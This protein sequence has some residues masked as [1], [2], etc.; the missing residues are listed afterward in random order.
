MEQFLSVK[1]EAYRGVVCDGQY[2]DCLGKGGPGDGV[3]HFFT[4]LIGRTK[5]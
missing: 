1:Q 2:K 4:F 5:M 3:K